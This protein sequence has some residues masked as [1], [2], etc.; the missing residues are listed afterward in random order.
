[1][2]DLKFN[3]LRD[4]LNPLG[5]DALIAAYH[6]CK[7]RG[8]PYVELVHWLQMILQLPNSDLH[9]IVRHFEIDRSQLD[10]DLTR[11]LDELPRRPGSKP[12]YSSDFDAVLKSAWTY[13][14]L[15]C[16]E[17]Q[18]RTGHLI[19]GLLK[20]SEL[21]ESDAALRRR[22]A[23]LGLSE[24]WEKLKPEELTDNFS[25]I[26]RGSPEDGMLPKDGKV[27]AKSGLEAGASES[28]ARAAQD[29]VLANYSVDLIEK[30]QKGEIDPVIGRDA[31]I[32]FLIS[33]LMRRRQNN[34]V[35]VGEAGVGKTAIAEGLALRILSG[36]VP[37]ALK[38]VSLR[39]LDVVALQAGASMK[40]EFEQRLRSV[41]EEIQRSSQPIILFIDEVH[42]LIGAGG[43]AGTG[44][45]ANLLKPALARG[46]LRTIGA[47]TWDE[48]RKHI[49][50]DPALS[51]RFEKVL[52]EEPSEIKSIIM[53]RRSIAP[54]ETKHKV[55]ILDEAI[56]AA[57]RLSKRY[58]PARQLPDKAVSLIDTAAAKV[59]MSQD[60]QPAQV[61]D[62]LRHLE[63]LEHERTRL[64]I[65]TGIG[66]DHKARLG[67]L[68]QLLL[69][70]KKRY[71]ELKGRWDEQKQ[72]V[73]EILDR[74]ARLRAA[75]APVDVKPGEAAPGSLG[76]ASVDA[77]AVRA[78][79]VKLQALL[80]ASQGDN[81]LLFPCVDRG[82]IASV[83][84]EW[85]GIP[86]GR[87]PRQNTRD[88]LDLAD[89]L[90]RRVIGQRH[91]LDSVARSLQNSRA[92]LANPNRPVGVFLFVG[93]S[94][95]GKTETALAL[96]EALFGSEQNLLTIN[97]SEFQEP[98]TV[99]TLKGAP[100][101]YVGYG[102]GGVLTEPV[103]RRPY[104]VVLLDEV[105]KAHPNVNRIFFQVFDKGWM[106]DAEGR[107][108][109]FRNTVI[110]LTSNAAQD[111]IFKQCKDPDTVPDAQNLEKLLREPL[112]KHFPDAL[113]NRLVVVPFY[114]LSKAM[115][116]QIVRL[117]LSRVSQRL[118]EHHKVPLTYDESVVDLIMQ[119]CDELERGA[120]MVEALIT[121]TMLPEI[122]RE[123]LLRSMDDRP[124]TKV[125]VGTENLS[126]KYS[127]E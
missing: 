20:E 49:E 82:M 18:I 33:I 109:D 16:G 48:Y 55:Q 45:A 9:R 19:I 76:M 74:R 106:E 51:R 79:L 42:T 102:E 59:A 7:T 119:R 125:N 99:S 52:V 35:L 80:A 41:I 75:G 100:P 92:K 26:V 3:V 105:E 14:T 124:V 101:G 91:A 110:V 1:M 5:L 38:G 118:A 53:L 121:Q 73:R 61:E 25:K 66:L 56:D 21:S 37:S 88:V 57:V 60:A 112:L 89:Q 15:M 17:S 111:V 117:G 11:S 31:E 46:T 103:R 114:P 72:L 70:E 86:V 127:F 98:H 77:D 58:I 78:E 13:A 67:E 39:A 104:T 65:E 12:E 126:F 116:Q 47:T 50:K 6:T 54:L 24:Q 94:G 2:A 96:A 84:A 90:E 34:P 107:F 43:S 44:D 97:M 93:P 108:I 95:T 4:K 28:A 71:A 29:G 23:F 63:A 8:N 62:A 30:A 120:R 68:E 115:L 123:V 81:P 85:T 32:R 22:R 10:R 83:V 69:E 64:Q 40:G 27:L 87:M 36:D 122:S 113:L